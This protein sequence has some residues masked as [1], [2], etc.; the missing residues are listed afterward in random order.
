MGVAQALAGAR[1]VEIE[2]GE[3]ARI[4]G[5]AQAQVDGV[6]AGEG[7]DEVVNVE[8]GKI[9]ADL[10]KVVFAVTAKDEVD[11]ISVGTHSAAKKP[12]TTVGMPARTSSRGLTT[13]R[14]RLAAY[15]DI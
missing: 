2:A 4:G 11:E 6:G 10:D 13:D 14:K 9:P 12:S 3:V 15:S 7:D 1:G 8:L 5:V